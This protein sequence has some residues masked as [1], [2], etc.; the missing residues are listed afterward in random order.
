VSV[1]L[2]PTLPLVPVW[3]PVVLGVLLVVPAVFPGMELLLPVPEAPVVVCVAVTPWFS[4]TGA[5]FV[6]LTLPA[7]ELPV[8]LPELLPAPLLPPAEAVPA[9]PV[10]LVEFAP[11]AA[12]EPEPVPEPPVC[13]VATPKQRS[14]AAVIPNVVRILKFPP[15]MAYFQIHEVAR[16]GFLCD[17]PRLALDAIKSRAAGWGGSR[18]HHQT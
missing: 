2:L 8:T 12:P 15:T 7:S 10:E 3:L 6:E 11:V 16:S 4:P 9:D 18:R 13:A 17:G 14:N 1:L 5:V